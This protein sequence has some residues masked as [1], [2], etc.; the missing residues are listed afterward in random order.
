MLHVSQPALS[1]RLQVLE[2][3]TGA[4]LLE[5]SSRGVSLT[6]VGSK[7]Y[8]EARKLLTQV[9][10]IEELMAGA[11]GQE[12]PVKF[13]AS[14]TIAEYVLPGLLADF[15][16]QHERHLSV[17][18]LVG[19][20]SVAR[21]AVRDGRADVGIVGATRQC[22]RPAADEIAEIPFLDDEVVLAV[23]HAHPWSE[24]KQIPRSEFLETPLVLRDPGAHSRQVVEHVLHQHGVSLAQPLAEMGSTRA[25]IQ[26]A[27]AE[28]V[29]AIL[30]R[31][32]TEH[33]SGE[34]VLRR[35]HG[36]RFP[37]RFV[38]V[39]ANSEE[40]LPPSARTLVRY[41]LEQRQGKVT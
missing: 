23:P 36:L 27:V 39:L 15:E 34:L 40:T 21:K 2:T 10:T 20:S 4:S 12:A 29:P 25:V 24:L 38:M 14:H 11:K 33:Y 41:L 37:R 16:G 17:E 13:T 31:L 8:M 6:P 26:T 9:E 22:D 30:S 28:N 32:A 19:N 5:R 35:V 18:L 1:K 7:L 3:L